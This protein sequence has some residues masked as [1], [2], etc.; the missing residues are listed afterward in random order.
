M[1]ASV[2]SGMPSAIQV[3]RTPPGDSLG[4][5]ALQGTRVTDAFGV[6]LRFR[7]AAAGGCQEPGGLAGA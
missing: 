1:V 4:S 5:G 3:I 6:S 2:R 7:R